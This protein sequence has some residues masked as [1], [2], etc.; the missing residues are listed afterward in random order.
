MSRHPENGEENLSRGLLYSF[1]AV[2]FAVSLVGFMTGTAVRSEHL[3]PPPVEG[4]AE[5]ADERI[6]V[7]RSYRQLRDTPRG[8][9]GAWD[10]SR[11]VADESRPKDS[12]VASLAA[13]LRQRKARR[14]Y[15]G[16]PPTIPHLVR[17]DRAA[18]CMACHSE[19]LQLGAK[20]AALLPHDNFSQCTQ[21]HVPEV[22]DLPKVAGSD[23]RAVANDF[24]G[25][26]SPGKGPRAWNIAPPQ[27]PHKSFM[28]ENCLS[29]HG[30]QGS[31]PLQTSHTDRQ[32]CTQC[33]T[34]SAELD[35]RPGLLPP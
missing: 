33:H 12:E 13:L 25:A 18:D 31:A 17:Q 19:G 6:P 14:A 1:V 24:V 23:P 15:D 29:C 32:N 4:P 26:P 11:K 30:S 28:R 22:V 3:R 34:A 21:C 7:A 27:I 9:G 10:E 20:R 8:S 5:A 2:V 16:A 35:L